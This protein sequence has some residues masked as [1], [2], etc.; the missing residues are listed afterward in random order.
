MWPI[1]HL[2][3]SWHLVMET[4]DLRTWVLGYIQYYKCM[5]CTYVVRSYHRAYFEVDWKNTH[6]TVNEVLS[7][8]Y[9]KLCRFRKEDKFRI[10][11]EF[12]PCVCL[13]V[14]DNEN[15]S[16][17]SKIISHCQLHGLLIEAWLGDF[18]RFWKLNIITTDRVHITR[19]VILQ[20]IVN[21][22]FP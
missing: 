11:T 17:L 3:L 4:S 13:I 8:Y 15:F 9:E 22:T 18:L 2:F 19:T 20:S 5:M 21:Y 16:M 14:E 12:I 6:I 10:A 1:Q 7:L